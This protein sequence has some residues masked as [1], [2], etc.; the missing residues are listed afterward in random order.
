MA[1]RKKETLQLSLYY[2]DR[3]VSEEDAEKISS[4]LNELSL[5]A[6]F[7]AIAA[8]L[9][10]II[11]QNETG[12]AA[13]LDPYALAMSFIKH[14]IDSL[15]LMDIR[16]SSLTV[17]QLE[18]LVASDIYSQYGALFQQYPGI[19]NGEK[20]TRE[21]ANKVATEVVDRLLARR[22]NGK[23]TI[24]SFN[25]SECAF[26]EFEFQLFE[27]YYN[28]EGDLLIRPTTE[29]A[30]L[31]LNAMDQKLGDKQAALTTLI[32]R[33][34]ERGDY[35]SALKSAF[36]HRNVTLQHQSS[37]LSLERQIERNSKGISWL[38]EIEPEISLIT[39]EVPEFNRQDE[40]IFFSL[41]A[42]LETLAGQK[43][44][45]AYQVLEIIRE[46]TSIYRRLAHRVM[47]LPE[48][49]RNAR[50][51]HGL[52]S[53]V[54]PLPNIETAILDPIMKHFTSDMLTD[55]LPHIMT[56]FCSVS[57][58]CCHDVKYMADKLTAPKRELAEVFDVAA[59]PEMDELVIE[60]IRNISAE[61]RRFAMSAL[62]RTC[63]KQAQLSQVISG[64]EE[65]CDMKDVSEALLLF[66]VHAWKE[67]G[68]GGL[69]ATQTNFRF[70]SRHVSGDDF[71]IQ[72]SGVASTM[73]E[74]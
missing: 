23:F 55:I 29:C 60:E 4:K 64:V 25:S 30:N 21:D 70:A 40:K 50:I 69:T 14:V 62:A 59:L 66:A 48:K 35:E 13:E 73:E 19:C 43:L 52:F 31:Y 65:D 7:L 26:R 44:Y 72:Y 17:H 37:I 1:R 34:I 5:R 67:N 74:Q 32:D 56:A 28:Y 11:P 47:G 45:L 3:A 46:C 51:Q 58:P 49:Y 63:G 41:Q 38:N 61:G 8:P 16:E 22:T 27:Q 42:N 2:N 39:R 53:V 71:L 15:K 6:E 24:R 20:P 33:Q 68:Y 18:A 54:T 36:Q 12:F 10:K 57:V 9:V